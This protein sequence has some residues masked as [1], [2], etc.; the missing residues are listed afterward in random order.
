M[1]QIPQRQPIILRDGQR[2]KRFRTIFLHFT[3]FRWSFL[4]HRYQ[5]LNSGSLLLTQIK[6]EEVEQLLNVCLDGHS[7]EKEVAQGV[8]YF[9]Y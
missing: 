9:I 1:A 6:R 8:E 3:H 4:I 5:E 2:Q 7:K